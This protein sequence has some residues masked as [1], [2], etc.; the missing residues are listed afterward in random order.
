MLKWSLVTLKFLW[1]VT[2]KVCD[3][4]KC[5]FLGQDPSNSFTPTPTEIEISLIV[6]FDCFIALIQVAL[7]ILTM[8]LNQTEKFFNNNCNFN[9]KLLSDLLG[10]IRNKESK[11]G[12]R[13]M[14]K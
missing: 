1:R 8:N 2:L 4:L 3:R 7:V 9:E 10:D 6:E 11:F 14:D 12:Q 5:N 13:T